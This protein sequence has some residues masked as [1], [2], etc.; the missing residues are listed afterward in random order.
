MDWAFPR[1]STITNYQ[2]WNKKENI[3]IVLPNKDNESGS[4]DPATEGSLEPAG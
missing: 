3:F 2:N 4:K 1:K